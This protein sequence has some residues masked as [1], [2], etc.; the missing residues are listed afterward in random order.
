MHASVCDSIADLVQNAVEAGASRVELDVYTGPDTVKVR[1]TDNGTV[2]L[3][4]APGKGTAVGFAF[5][6]RHPDTPPLGDLPATVVGLMTLSGVCDLLLTRGTPAGGYT[7]AER[8]ARDARR[9]RDRGQPDSGQR[10]SESSRGLF[11]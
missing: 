5:D 7:R 10:L 11:D 2:D 8:A 3:Q 9:P 1:V 4:S 6:A